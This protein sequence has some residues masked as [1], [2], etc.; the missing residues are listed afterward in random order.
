MRLLRLNRVECGLCHDV[1]TSYHRHDHVTCK[2]GAIFTD[3]GRTYF[4]RGGTDEG[5]AA[6]IDRSSFEELPDDGVVCLP[7]RIGS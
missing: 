4:H 1:I 5:V 3:G 2:C 6:M 7:Q